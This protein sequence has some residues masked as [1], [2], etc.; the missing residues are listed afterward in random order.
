M[1][2]GEG[3]VGSL[4]LV[5]VGDGE[6]YLLDVCGG[7]QVYAPGFPIRTVVQSSS[8]PTFINT[9]TVS[10]PPF[11]PTSLPRVAPT[12]H[13]MPRRLPTLRLAKIEISRL[14]QILGTPRWESPCTGN[15]PR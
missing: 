9:I 7:G 8:I 2:E 15:A 13:A 3:G 4:V 5:I 10:G 14:K 11:P 1:R 6:G 12:A